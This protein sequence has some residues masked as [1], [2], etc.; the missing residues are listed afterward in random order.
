[1]PLKTNSSIINQ[2]ITPQLSN[3]SAALANNSNANQSAQL[4]NST[5]SSDPYAGYPTFR[6]D[7]YFTFINFQMYTLQNSSVNT[8]ITLYSFLAGFFIIFVIT[9]LAISNKAF[10]ALKSED[11]KDTMKFVVR[12]LSVVMSLF[13]FILEIP[14]VTI[15]LQ[16]FLCEENPNLNYT[17]PEIKC[18]STQ[19]KILLLFS[20]LTITLYM[21]FLVL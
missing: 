12:L 14:L 18:D 13:I 1:V 11:I 20:S 4:A 21:V 5:V 7:Y 9:L 19:H 15:L 6:I 8:F 10:E 16:G 17:L 2:G 3:I